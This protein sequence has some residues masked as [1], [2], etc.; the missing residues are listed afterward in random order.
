MADLNLNQ[1][2][3]PL[4]IN[5]Y[6][7]PYKTNGMVSGTYTLDITGYNIHQIQVVGNLNLNFT[8]WRSE[9]GVF[10]SLILFVINGGHT[11]TWPS[12]VINGP[13]IDAAGR[14]LVVLTT[15]NNGLE[16]VANLYG[17]F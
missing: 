9:S 2:M 14:Y 6:L 7:E 4:K 13:N 15:P 10:Q 3:R 11:V 5:D 17:Q 12:E 16:I 8:G 1:V